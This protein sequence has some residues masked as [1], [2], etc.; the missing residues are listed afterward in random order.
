MTESGTERISILDEISRSGHRK[1]MRAAYMS[2][3]MKNAPDHN[4]LELYLSLLIPRKD[5]KQLAYDLINHFGSLEGVFSA[6]AESLMN[7][8][9]VGESTAVAI[10]LSYAINSRICA[11]R[12]KG[13]KRLAD[14]KQLIEFC[15]N[16]LKNEVRE[17]LI[18]ITL[19]NNLDIINTYSVG[20]GSSNEMYADTQSIVYNAVKDKASYVALAHNHPGGSEKPSQADID[21]TVEVK[22]VLTKIN[23]RLLEHVIVGADASHCISRNKFLFKK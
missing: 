3:G 8:N 15:E 23:I 5:V 4:L 6:D 12:N 9:R 19:S 13:V 16:L 11:N 22:F 1:R 17:K 10:S 14:E 7:V 18:E 21:F 2:G 20:S